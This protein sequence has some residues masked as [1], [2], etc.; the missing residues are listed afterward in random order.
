MEPR[1][2]PLTSLQPSISGSRY[3]TQGGK[4]RRTVFLVT[5]S[6]AGNLKRPC[7]LGYMRLG[8]ELPSAKQREEKHEC[9]WDWHTKLPLSQM[10]QN[11][12]NLPTPTPPNVDDPS[13]IDLAPGMRQPDQF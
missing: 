6:S 8:M 2:E 5:A 1:E 13:L 4:Y 3:L 12:P 7:V 10:W 9:S 11:P